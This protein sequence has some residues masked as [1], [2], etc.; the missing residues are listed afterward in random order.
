M[1][2]EYPALYDAV[3]AVAIA[4][5]VGRHYPGPGARHHFAG[6][7]IGFLLQAGLPGP[8]AMAVLKSAAEIAADGDWDDRK[9]F[10]RTTIKAFKDGARVTGGPTL[11]D[12]LGEDVVAKLRAWLKLADLDSLLLMN[13]KHF[14]VRM[15][16]SRSSVGRMILRVSSSSLSGS[17]SPNMQISQC[18]LGRTKRVTPSGRLYLTHGSSRRNGGHTRGL[19]SPRRR[20][21]PKRATTT[22]GR[23]SRLSLRRASA[24]NTCYT[25][26]TWCAAAMTS[27]LIT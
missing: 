26:E 20:V 16:A 5:L 15:G 3:A 6:P 8:L 2:L 24:T 4:A 19:F 21:W 7:M 12:S 23:A 17:S 14:F 1:V 13:D 27:T 25:C 9:K 10:A 22:C 11:V 18:R